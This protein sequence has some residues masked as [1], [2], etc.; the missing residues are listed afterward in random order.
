M[1]RAL[2]SAA[3]ALAQS[4]ADRNRLLRYLER[5]EAQSGEKRDGA[6]PT[7]AL[8][9]LAREAFGWAAAR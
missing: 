9:R 8:A 1:K 7:D 3:A 5:V 6:E 2:A 4:Q